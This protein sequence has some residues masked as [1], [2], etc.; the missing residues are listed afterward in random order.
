MECFQTASTV[1]VLANIKD[2]NKYGE[3][4]GAVNVQTSAL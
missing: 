3:N 1:H 4:I 2:E